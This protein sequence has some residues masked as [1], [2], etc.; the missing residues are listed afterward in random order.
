MSYSKEIIDFHTHLG[1]AR[2]G[3]YEESGELQ[4]I[5]YGKTTDGVKRYMEEN[6]IDKAV[7]FALPMLPT[8]QKK[9]NDEIVQ[10]VKNDSSLIPFAFLDP[11][12]DESPQLLREY[13]SKGCKGL[14]LHPVC[15]GYVV[16]NSLSY[17]TI[18]EARSLDIPVLIHTGWGE[19]GEVRFIKKLA[20]DFKNLKIVIGHTIE[21]QDIFTIIPPLKNVAVETSYSSHPR[22]IAQAVNILGSDRVVFGSDMPLGVSGFELVKIQMS[23][24]SDSDKEKI[25]SLNARRL[26]GF[27]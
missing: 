25:L 5:E 8:K 14:K 11:R 26:L 21:Y 19:Y 13:V 22:R 20:E 15:H 1:S 7:V 27:S 16:S 24:I 10:L 23:P 6:K 12:L 2:A 9:A 4:M 18:E 17:P 3:T